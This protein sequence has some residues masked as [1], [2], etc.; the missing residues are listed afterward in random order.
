MKISHMLAREDFYCIIS[1]TLKRYY[2]N[3]EKKTKLYVY[4]Q[5]NAIVSASP[6]SKVKQ[7]LYTEYKVN[8]SLPK[9]F[10]V[11]AYCHL[12]MNTFGLLAEKKLE[13]CSD[14]GADTLIYPCNRKIRIFDFAENIVRVV[15]KW[16]FPDNDLQREIAF[17]T[18]HQ[19]EFIPK[20]LSFDEQGYTE[21]IIDGYPLARAS[22]KIEEKSRQ[23]YEIWRAY[24]RRYDR[25]VLLNQYIAELNRQYEADIRQLKQSKK[26]PYEDINQYWKKLQD[27]LAA[28]DGELTL[29]LSHGDLQPGNI[30]I[31]NNSENIVI[32]DWE[33]YSERSVS[34]D[35]ALL[36][37]ELRKTKGLSR[38]V[39]E[40]KPEKALVLAE[41]ILFRLHEL[42]E[43]PEQFGSKDF[44]QYLETVTGGNRIHV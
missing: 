3:A 40:M 35:A 15:P 4:P 20:L 26:L 38:Y 16:S 18:H 44:A 31:D 22:E 14:A 41:D 19:A 23:A 1:H 43:L 6:S 30:W 7:Y 13:L 21:E 28:E 24:T 8:A 34:Y 11:N 2:Q 39:Q 9:R 17:R 32:I 27:I 5:L 36:F 12:M 33:S 37:S 10:L 25:T 42:N 29:T